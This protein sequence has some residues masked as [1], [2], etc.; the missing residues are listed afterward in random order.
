VFRDFLA[1]EDFC[2]QKITFDDGYVGYDIVCDNPRSINRL[3]RM[4]DNATRM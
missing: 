4:L 2:I 1:S 3:E